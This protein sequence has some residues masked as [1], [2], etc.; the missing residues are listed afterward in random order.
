MPFGNSLSCYALSRK[1][2]TRHTVANYEQAFTIC[3]QNAVETIPPK[4]YNIIRKREAENPNKPQKEKETMTASEMIKDYNI[5]LDP[6]KPGML[7]AYNVKKIKADNAGKKITEAKP[8]IMAILTAEKEAKEKEAAERTAKINA[9]EG[10]N[11]IK[12]AIA[13]QERFHDA[14]NAAMERGDGRLPSRPESNIGEMKAKYPRAA[15]YLKAENYEYSA[16]YAQ[17]SAGRKA[18][19]R[20]IN[21]EDYEQVLTDMEKEWSD[22]CNEHVWD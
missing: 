13:E 6:V 8:E 3:L 22:Y 9:I 2:G 19:E 14:F 10:L 5:T 20:I 15:A 7:R 21:G 16:N 1:T 11:E 12:V 4:W 18:R 17:A